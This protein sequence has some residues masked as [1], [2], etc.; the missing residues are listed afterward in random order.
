MDTYFMPIDSLIFFSSISLSLLMIQIG[1]ARKDFAGVNSRVSAVSD[2]LDDAKCR[3]SNYPLCGGT[4]APTDAPVSS[5]STSSRTGSG[6][7]TVTFVVDDYPEE[8][9]WI[10]S[11]KDGETLYF[12]P[13]DSLTTP[14]ATVSKR[15]D[16]LQE[17]ETYMFK[18]SDREGDGM[19]CI[20]GNGE[21]TIRDNVQGV[22]VWSSRGNYGRYY[23]VDLEIQSNT[24]HAQVVGRSGQYQP[25]S[26]AALE[27]MMAPEN[28]PE[29]PGTL[30]IADAF[31]LVVNV[32]T[33]DYPEENTW[34]LLHQDPDTEV[35]TLI[36]QWDGAEA[37]FRVLE[38]FEINNLARG[39]YRFV[40]RDSE[41]DGNCCDYGTGYVTLTGPLAISQGQ[42]GLVWGND[43]KFWAMDE[44]FFEVDNSG[45]ISHID[46][47]GVL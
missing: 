2:W 37:G 28:E 13:Y 14:R 47:H 16:N 20:F 25:S 18:V 35:W 21:V 7:L 15:F 1:C 46:F 31:S 10:M 24:G 33:D 41:G 5:P 40:I 34:E 36:D 42:K 17:G 12:Q 8:L 4:G 29:W 26:W 11:Q 6:S 38:S 22:H 43:G 23:E 3:Y 44:I 30:P 27:E 39:W 45:Y 32:D 9:A 19:C